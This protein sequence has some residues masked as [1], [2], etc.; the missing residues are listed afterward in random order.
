VLHGLFLFPE[1]FR[2]AFPQGLFTLNLKAFAFWLFIH[3]LPA[4]SVNEYGGW[5][6]GRLG[7]DSGR[8]TWESR[9]P[10]VA[11]ARLFSAQLFVIVGSERA[12]LR[13]KNRFGPIRR[14]I[15]FR[16]P[17]TISH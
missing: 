11:G 7:G 8:G 14:S 13:T 10:H 4:G 15:Y 3:K 5:E 9:M 12:A 6:S 1:L 16:I 2:R 17:G